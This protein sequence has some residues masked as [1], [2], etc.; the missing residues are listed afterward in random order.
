MNKK[1][2]QK[3]NEQTK[4]TT[5]KMKQIRIRINL[6]LKCHIKQS[7]IICVLFKSCIQSAETDSDTHTHTPV[8]ICFDRNRTQPLTRRASK[9]ITPE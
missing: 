8:Y 7:V 9:E 1:Q 4:Q 2:K 3:L 6:Q 5:T